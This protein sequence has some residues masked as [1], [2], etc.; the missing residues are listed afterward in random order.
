[1]KLSSLHDSR[2]VLVTGKGGTGKTSLASALGRM[3][4]RKGRRV[5]LVEV[6]SFRPALTAMFGRPPTYTPEPVGDGLFIANLSW[7]E[8]LTE[9]LSDTVPAERIVKLI[10]GNR[11]VQPFLEATPGLKELVILSRIVKLTQEFDQVIVDMPASGHAIS[12]MG[13]PNVAIDLMR[14][15]PIRDRAD[16]ILRALES[17]DTQLVIVALP[18]EMVV[19]ETVE[20]WQRM[21]KEVPRLGAPMVVLNRA[22][23]PSLSDDERALLTRLSEGADASGTP[24]RELLLAGRWEAGLEGAT[25]AAM[26]RLDAELSE[27]TVVPLAR[28]GALGGLQ[29]GADRIVEQMVSALTRIELRENQS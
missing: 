12:L 8:A 15:G 26:K 2:L 9:Y 25:D 14:S 24:V 6:D 1:M 5:A 16:Q 18:E 19:N 23:L 20:L 21:Q 29:G 28:L 11:V 17:H 27:A 4:A 13:V 3:T 22:A 7:R 10:L